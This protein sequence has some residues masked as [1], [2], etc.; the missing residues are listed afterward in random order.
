VWPAGRPANDPTDRFLVNHRAVTPG[1]FETV[2]TEL[3]AGRTF[4]PTDGPDDPGVVVVSRATA[5]RLWPGEE[6]VGRRVRNGA[7]G[8]TTPWLTVVGVVV[9]VADYGVLTETWYRPYAQSPEEFN[10]RVLEIFVRL[11]GDPETVLP[12]VRE[13]VREAAPT[14]PVFDL[15]PVS[16]VVSFER[17]I[18]TF[19]TLL[20]TLFAGLGI[21]LAAVGVYGILSFSTGRRRREI[22]LRLALGARGS[23]V[24]LGLLGG[25][26]RTTALGLALGVAGAALLTG[27]LDAFLV[28]VSP[29]SPRAYVVAVL[30]ALAV[31]VIA[32]LLPSLRALRVDPRSALAA[33]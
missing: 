2:G 18:E 17:R 32:A 31:S 9:D 3:L 19:G 21:T 11:D 27:F 5:H 4:A 22:G 14:L 26:V 20:L 23:E 16:Q 1:W 13:A 24:V 29:L 28:G 15:A 7:A 25:T 10:T 6:A 30:T 12:G 33:E 8:D